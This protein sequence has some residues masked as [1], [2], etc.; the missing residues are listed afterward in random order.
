[1]LQ[2]TLKVVSDVTAA[3]LIFCHF[4]IGPL[5]FGAFARSI[6]GRLYFLPCAYQFLLARYVALCGLRHYCGSCE[7]GTIFSKHSWKGMSWF[8]E[9]DIWSPPHPISCQRD[10]K[11]LNRSK[12]KTYQGLVGVAS[13]A[14]PMRP[15]SSRSWLFSTRTGLTICRLDYDDGDCDN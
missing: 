7:V 2:G 14:E 6:F 15:T 11:Y 13:S 1:M 8:V 4:Y 12:H 9:L 10:W 5:A 3:S